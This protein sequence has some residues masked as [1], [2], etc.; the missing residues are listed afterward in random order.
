M[1]V[2]GSSADEVAEKLNTLP[3]VQAGFLAP[4]KIIPVKPYSGF[5]PRPASRVGS[6]MRGIQIF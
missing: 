4:P 2:E 1:I 3:L 5:A 6:Q